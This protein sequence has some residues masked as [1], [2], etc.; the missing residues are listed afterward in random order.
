MYAEVD[1]TTAQQN[2]ALAV[3]VEAVEGSGESARVFAVDQSGAI[4]IVAVRLGIET[5]Q[6]V[7]IRSGDLKEGDRVVVG[8]RSALKDGTHVQ[9]KLISLGSGPPQKS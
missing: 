6:L 2:H 7:E 5:S 8:S 9:P 4:R 3:P 1:L